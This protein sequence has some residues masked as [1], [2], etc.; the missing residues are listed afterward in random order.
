MLCAVCGVNV[1]TM[2]HEFFEGKKENPVRVWSVTAPLYYLS[3][4]DY[5][6]VIEGYCSAAHALAAHQKREIE[7]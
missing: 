2:E 4:P 6:G 3:T 5:T 7:R 1:Q